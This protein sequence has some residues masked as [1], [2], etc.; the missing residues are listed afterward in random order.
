M[1]KK[2]L[3]KGEVEGSN[4]PSHK[5][6]QAGGVRFSWRF[7]YRHVSAEDHLCTGRDTLLVE[8]A[9]SCPYC[10][11]RRA[12]SVTHTHTYAAVQLDRCLR[13]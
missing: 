7:I 9:G 8:Q 4:L 13:D 11:D 1:S 2:R 3:K 6:T 5:H 10:G 12:F